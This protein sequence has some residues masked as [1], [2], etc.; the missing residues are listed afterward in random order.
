M[1]LFEWI[2]RT[3]SK[4][5]RMLESKNYDSSIQLLVHC[6]VLT[7]K[8]TTPLEA[9]NDRIQFELLF[10]VFVYLGVALGYRGQLSNA[11]TFFERVKIIRKDLRKHAESR[12]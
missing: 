8:W 5:L 2:A 3:K 9:F 1:E 7:E 12:L 11:L 4:A 6:L 10:P